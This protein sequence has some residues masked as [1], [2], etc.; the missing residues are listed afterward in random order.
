M[1]DRKEEGRWVCV[2]GWEG[3]S[4]LSLWEGPWGSE[5]L[6]SPWTPL[7]SQTQNKCLPFLKHSPTDT[8]RKLQG[9]RDTMFLWMIC[10]VLLCY[11]RLSYY[12]GSNYKS[13]KWIEFYGDL[14]I[15]PFIKP[16][17]LFYIYTIP[18]SHN[19]SAWQ[20]SKFSCLAHQTN[21]KSHQ[22]YRSD[23]RLTWPKDHFYHLPV[24]GYI[25]LIMTSDPWFF[26]FT[27]GIKICFLNCAGTN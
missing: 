3:E 12:T 6:L 13:D 2:W 27:P 8:H 5:P 16:S 17:V 4:S 21:Q 22:I 18:D 20:P 11:Y 7:C 1:E 26:A 15:Y 23:Y 14:S 19:G 9:R 24:F 25:I 10:C